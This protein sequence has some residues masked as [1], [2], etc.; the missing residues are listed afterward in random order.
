MAIL[1][2]VG[3]KGQKAARRGVAARDEGSDEVSN[4]VE[5]DS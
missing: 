1:L 3:R 5:E 2:V 4:A